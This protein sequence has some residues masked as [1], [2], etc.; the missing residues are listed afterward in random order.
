MADR[1][2]FS[3]RSFWVRSC[4][5]ILIFTWVLGLCLGIGFGRGLPDSFSSLM[6]AAAFDRVSIVGLF[7]VLLVPFLISAFAVYFS[8]PAAILPVILFKAFS[9]GCSCSG[10]VHA[11]G[12]AAW[13]VRILLLFSDCVGTTVLLWFSLRSISGKRDTFL[14]DTALCVLICFFTGAVDYLLVSPFLMELMY[15]S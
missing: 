13:L 4:T 15:H 10:I 8:A 14:K 11:F 2:M 1:Q 12:S 5:V 9:F 7:T 6:R 3:I